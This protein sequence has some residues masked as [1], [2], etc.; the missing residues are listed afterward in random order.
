M[1]VLTIQALTAQ[2]RRW[3]ES[4]TVS[5]CNGA[6]TAAAGH[7]ASPCALILSLLIVN[8]FTNTKKPKDAVLL[9]RAYIVSGL[10]GASIIAGI[11]A[12]CAVTYLPLLEEYHGDTHT[13]ANA[14]VAGLGAM[15]GLC[16]LAVWMRA[17][18][19]S[20]FAVGVGMAVWCILE[21]ACSLPAV[22]NALALPHCT[23]SYPGCELP[24]AALVCRCFLLAFVCIP[25][26]RWSKPPPARPAPTLEHEGSRLSVI[27]TPRGK[28]SFFD[29]Q[30][31]TALHNFH[32]EAGIFSQGLL[33]WVG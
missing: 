23:Y 2:A 19:V 4:I 20:E 10:R 31:K 14:A 15:S 26:A 12:D 28:E 1:S 21:I 6:I 3:G 29:T 11:V 18:P 27:S 32:E 30:R 7:I 9:F 17:P 24:L 16:C 33:L 13:A 8:S 22:E 5:P 25:T